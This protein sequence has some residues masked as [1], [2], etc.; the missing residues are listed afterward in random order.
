MSPIFHNE[1]SNDFWERSGPS[2]I[3]SY[4]FSPPF[5]GRRLQGWDKFSP[6]L[7]SLLPWLPVNIDLASWINPKQNPFQEMMILKISVQ[8]HLTWGGSPWRSCESSP[9][10]GCSLTLGFGDLCSIIWKQGASKIS[11][12]IPRQIEALKY[13]WL[14]LWSRN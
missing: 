14:Y 7:R 13:T 8:L 2:F 6:I 1:S 12:I 3:P 4:L 9:D 10:T 5:T 11:C